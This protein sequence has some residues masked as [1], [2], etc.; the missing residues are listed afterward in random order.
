ME[1]QPLRFACCA[2]ASTVTP[3]PSVVG[4]FQAELHQNTDILEEQHR[5]NVQRVGLNMI[6]NFEIVIFAISSLTQEHIFQWPI[7]SKCIN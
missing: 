5:I 4:A 6:Y 3:V 7:S 2:I 1:K